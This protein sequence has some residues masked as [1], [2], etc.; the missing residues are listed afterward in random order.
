MAY[1][2]MVEKNKGN[3][4]TL[5]ITKTTLFARMSK[6]KGTGAT[7]EEIDTFTMLFNNEREL[8][9]YLLDEGILK[10]QYLDKPLSIRILRNNSYN[11]VPHS[12]LYQK[13]I[14]YVLN[15]HKLI[16]KINDK[17]NNGDFRFI[18]QYAN[19][20]LTFRDCSST[21]P[22]V[23]AF[24]RMSIK[25]GIKS[26]HFCELDEN[27]DNSLVRMTKLLIYE[28][29]QFSNGKISYQN[30]IKYRNLHS[31]IAFINNYEKKYEQE[32]ES[33]EILS[34]TSEYTKKRTRNIKTDLITEQLSLF[35]SF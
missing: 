26:R 8:R 13:D 23:R 7:L 31:I 10:I 2:F 5:D 32:L 3:H 28:Y 9:N 4:E 17:L 6:L 14:E 22:E 35:D 19:N 29:Y 33:K 25:E 15:P 21:A 24:A 27:Y 16:A 20:Y 34:S 30:R 1:Y 18:E 12:F 11:K